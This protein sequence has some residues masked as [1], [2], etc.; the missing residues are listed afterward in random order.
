[1][2]SKPAI[3]PAG[4]EGSKPATFPP[5]PGTLAIGDGCADFAASVADSKPAI[6]PAGSTGDFSSDF[7][8]DLPPDFSPN[9]PPECQSGGAVPTANTTAA[10]AVENRG[11]PSTC[12]PY[13]AVIQEK[14]DLGLS[15]QRIY[16]DLVSEHGFAGSYDS[17]KRF[18]RQQ[19]H[20][21]PL[22][23]RRIERGPGE[24]A[25][26]D[27]GSGAPIIGPDGKRRKTH[28]FRFVLSYSRAAFSVVTFRQTTE[29][30]IGCMEDA[31]IY[32]GGCPQVV[33][34]DNLRAAVKH[35]DWFDPELV[36]KLRSFCQ[37]YGIAIL[38]TKPYVPRHKGKV[39]SSVKYVQNNALKAKKFA[40]LQQQNE[41]LAH[42]EATVA[43]TRIH[44]TTRQHV[45]RIFRE[46][47]RPTLRPLPAERFSMFQEAPRKVNRD[48]HVEV[49]RAYYSAPPE[50]V[51]HT[52]W[53]RWDAR[54]VRIFNQRFEQ[55]AIHVRNEKGRFSTQSQHLAPEKINGIER[56]AN[57]LL[58]KV[59]RIGSHT[60]QW[61][62]AMLH[63][64]GI[65][66]T[67]VLQGVISLSRKHH[68]EELEKA[69][70]KAL[71]HGVFHLRTLRQLIDRQSS[72][73]TTFAFLEEHPIIR[74]MDDYAAVV[75]AALARKASHTAMPTDAPE[76]RFERHDWTKA[77]PSS[78]SA[79]SS[80]SAPN[81]EQPVKCDGPDGN[82]H[83][84][85]ADMLPPKSSYPLSGCSPAE[86]DSVSPDTSSVITPF[87]FDY[88]KKE[89]KC[90]E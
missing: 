59:R 48:G 58:E 64:R 72:Q 69:C 35:P 77:L 63:A 34:I 2:N 27:F 33:V 73:Q 50:Y 42:W 68:S 70:E 55:I 86:P 12:L 83:Q 60:H 19:G 85:R 65:E 14:L 20:D 79:S 46:V 36:P 74:P 45:G 62:E 25:Q 81:N 44:G 4:S 17:V 66:G 8:P 5:F 54:L 22:P 75:E 51:G 3:S 78:P 1:S 57:Y 49:A 76:V 32:F 15:A 61:A 29:D 18:V 71:S 43:N 56:G 40:S 38:P 9:L 82:D 87:V 53:V 37:H 80:P 13:A 23:F 52:V 89:K 90:D 16:Q 84:G 39:E 47:E 11:R 88:L 7:P 10:T 28:V 41:Y 24:E 31:F 67:R 6:S 30:F 21:R 26:V